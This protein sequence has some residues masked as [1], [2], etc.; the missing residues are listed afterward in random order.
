MR[1]T[2]RAGRFAKFTAVLGTACLM[3]AGS[4]A[5]AL[6]N[7]AHDKDSAGPPT[8]TDHV[9]PM[10]SKERITVCPRGTTTFIDTYRMR[11]GDK[12]ASYPHNGTTFQTKVDRRGKYLSF[13]TNSPS[14]TIYIA[15]ARDRDHSYRWWDYGDHQGWWGDDDHHDGHGYDVYN[16]T[17]TVGHPAYLSDTGL[18][19]PSEE[20]ER[21]TTIS[22]YIVCGQPAKSI[23]SPALVTTPSAG[24][25]VG[26]A[27]LND[28]AALSGGS[29]PGG[30]I[31]FNLYAPS[32]TCGSG[33]PAYSQTVAV[34][35][36]GSYSTTNKVSANMAGTWSWTAVYSGD[37]GN[38]GTSSACGKETVEV[39]KAAPSFSTTPSAGGT[40]GTVDLND[41]AMVSGGY[42]TPTGTVTFN[43]YSPSQACGVGTP[44]FSQTVPVDAGGYAVT[45]HTSPAP[46][47][48]TWSWTA[49][50]SGDGNN[51]P[52]VSGCGVE[53][54][55]VT[56]MVAVDLTAMLNPA[57]VPATGD[58][59]NAGTLP[60]SVERFIPL[61]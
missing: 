1:P 5:V 40:V 28:K 51:N 4:T 39:T 3:A 33:A 19:A 27:T 49:S 38:K 6:A 59:C 48:G 10:F 18:H 61:P 60:S 14:F 47:A 23:A 21:P 55:K 34:S 11:P 29:S 35:G 32:Q 58:V 42:G 56:D 8:A 44:A 52:A 37:A 9:R 15:G 36:N 13:T 45:D 12:S 57:T 22:Y 50:Y 24:G 2:Q 53:T 20:R 17:G 41:S 46:S 43:L 25:T 7:P 26:V 54:V 30:S 31:T 16:Y